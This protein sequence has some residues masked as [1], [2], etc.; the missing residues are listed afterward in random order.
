MEQGN[1]PPVQVSSGIQFTKSLSSGKISH[2]PAGFTGGQK[3][4]ERNASA[5]F[6]SSSRK[7][8]FEGEDLH[9]S[10][11]ET[12]VSLLQCY[13]EYVRIIDRRRRE[14]QESELD[15]YV[16]DWKRDKDL[17]ILDLSSLEDSLGKGSQPNSRRSSLS[18]QRIRM[19]F[20]MPGIV[21]TE[22]S[23]PKT[24]PSVNVQPLNELRPIDIERPQSE[25][26]LTSISEREVALKLLDRWYW[27]HR[28]VCR[29]RYQ[30]GDFS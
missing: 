15:E 12:L 4:R 26:G 22:G 11:H 24:P 18:L 10:S 25:A 17:G 14:F 21:P 9:A 3:I 30:K 23:N 29:L 5:N 8:Y 2:S 16:Q 20:H 13:R 28:I 6:M 19:S 27:Y 1:A 7:P